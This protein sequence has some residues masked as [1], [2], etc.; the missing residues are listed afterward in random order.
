VLNNNC[1]DSATEVKIIQKWDGNR[2]AINWILRDF[3]RY[4]I[5]EKIDNKVAERKRSSP[6]TKGFYQQNYPFKQQARPNIQ[7]LRK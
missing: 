6:N 1:S 4:L 5:Q 2:P 3:R 7:F